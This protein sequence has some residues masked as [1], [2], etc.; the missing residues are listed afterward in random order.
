MIIMIVT[1]S[2]MTNNDNVYGGND[3]IYAS[4]VE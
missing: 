2:Y 1:D 4:D 3:F